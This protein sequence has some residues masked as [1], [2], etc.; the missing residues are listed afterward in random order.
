MELWLYIVI[1]LVGL[2]LLLLLTLLGAAIYSGLLHNIKV[3]VGKPPI[4]NVTIAYKF[5]R[6]PYSNCGKLFTEAYSVA[7]KLRTIGIYYDDP[8]EVPAEKLRWAVGSIIAE[9]NEEPDEGL[10]KLFERHGF[11][12]FNLPAVSNVV[13]TTFPYKTVLSIYIYVYR[14]YSAASKY[15]EDAGLDGMPYMDICDG[16]LMKFMAPLEL[17]DQFYVPEAVAAASD[18]TAGAADDDAAGAAGDR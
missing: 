14:V 16:S 4:S 2:L 9:G 11:K 3:D 1:A 8:Y 17:S 10:V 6:G 7:P 18:L 5:D 12:L 15:M 13:K